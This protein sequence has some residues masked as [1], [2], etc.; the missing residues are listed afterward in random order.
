LK[1]DFKSSSTVRLT[2]GK[3]SSDFK[4]WVRLLKVTDFQPDEKISEEKL[5]DVLR[6]AR[7]YD[8]VMSLPKRLE[9]KVG[10]RGVKLSG[11]EKQRVAIGRAILKEPQIL[12]LDEATSALDSI[13]EQQIQEALTDLM[14]NRTAIVVAHRLSTIRHADKIVVIEN[15]RLDE[16]GTLEELL[17]KK[18]GFY[19]YWEEQK[20]Y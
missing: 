9:T 6:K 3:N 2:R 8:L 16:Q 12:L 11:G 14:K 17:E 15:G 5:M 7:L 18:G 1:K 4:N 10:D 13:T 20:F 19:K